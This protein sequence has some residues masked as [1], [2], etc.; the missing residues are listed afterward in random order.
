MYLYKMMMVLKMLTRNLERLLRNQFLN[1]E[2]YLLMEHC[3][4]SLD[5]EIA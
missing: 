4:R 2:Q 3:K 5:M 1:E